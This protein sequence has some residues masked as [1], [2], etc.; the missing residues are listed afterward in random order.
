MANNRMYILCNKCCPIFDKMPPDG[1]FMV[2]KYYPS[3]EGGY[4]GGF[5]YGSP[6]KFG[7][8]LSNFMKEHEHNNEEHPLRMEYES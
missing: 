2:G 7:V 4:E 6:E 8:A 5:T 3:S 1:G